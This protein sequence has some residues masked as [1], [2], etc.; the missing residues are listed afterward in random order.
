MLNSIANDAGEKDTRPRV[1]AVPVD[2][3]FHYLSAIGRD[4]SNVAALPNGL[5]V[6]LD[7]GGDLG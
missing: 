6:D 2:A 4:D 1:A 5:Y 7:D 3:R